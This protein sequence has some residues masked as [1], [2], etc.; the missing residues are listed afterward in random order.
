VK[1]FH[2]TQ[3]ERLER[4][5]EEG[6]RPMP[7]EERNYPPHMD[8]GRG[9]AVWLTTED[10]NPHACFDV[11]CDVRI[12]LDL[13]KSRRLIHWASQIRRN[14]PE[15]FKALDDDTVWIDP[16]WRSYWFYRGIISPA[17]FIAFDYVDCDEYGKVFHETWEDRLNRLW[18]E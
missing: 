16:T 1:F 10:T 13:P 4:I 8:E 11:I 9:G 14:K 15:V 17:R 5:C 7:A 6:L 2:F 3:Y 18:E 12:T